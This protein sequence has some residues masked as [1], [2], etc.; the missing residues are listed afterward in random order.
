[1]SKSFFISLSQVLEEQG[2][3]DYAHTPERFTFTTQCEEGMR[4]GGHR[5]SLRGAVE[6]FFDFSTHALTIDVQVQL[7]MYQEMLTQRSADRIRFAYDTTRGMY[8]ARALKGEGVERKTLLSH[9]DESLAYLHATFAPIVQRNHLER[10]PQEKNSV[11]SIQVWPK[12]SAL[13][14]HTVHE[15]PRT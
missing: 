12:R 13:D 3:L 1:M 15:I 10:A 8:V 5:H 11:L 6:D 2:P 4:F 9:A 7:A 14:R